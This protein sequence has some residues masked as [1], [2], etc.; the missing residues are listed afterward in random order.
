M[1]VVLKE[2]QQ[3]FKL[4]NYKDIEDFVGCSRFKFDA[5]PGYALEKM[6]PDSG[7]KYIFKIYRFYLIEEF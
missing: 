4:Q 3:T 7:Q 6:V 1:N 2:D 5:A